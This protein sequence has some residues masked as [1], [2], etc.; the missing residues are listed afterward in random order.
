M[1]A[2]K[3]LRP[4]GVAIFS[5]HAWQT[6]AA[7]QVGEWVEAGEGPLVPCVNG[8]HASAP[9][10]LAFWLAEELWEVELDG[11]LIE[12]PQAIIARR[13]RLVRKVEAWNAT[14]A[15]ELGKVAAQR[16]T[17][18]LARA[19]DAAPDTARA[20]HREVQ[21][22]IDRGD[23]VVASYAAALAVSAVDPNADAN[24]AFQAERREQSRVLAQLLKL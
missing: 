21:G 11:E 6:P 7:G 3:F 17:D 13:G 19:G 24:A 5:G 1:I 15:L 23:G 18:A 12:G 9:H 10:D 14:T 20:Y 4:Q 8:V 16:A 2:F 22:F